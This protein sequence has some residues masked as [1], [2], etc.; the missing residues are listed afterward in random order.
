VTEPLPARRACCF[1]LGPI[2]FE[3]ARDKQRDVPAC[4]KCGPLASHVVVQDH[5]SLGVL[6]V[7][8]ARSRSSGVRFFDGLPDAP[9]R[10]E[11]WCAMT[12]N[13]GGPVRRPDTPE[14][15]VFDQAARR[16]EAEAERARGALQKALHV[17]GRDKARRLREARE[18]EAAERKRLSAIRGAKRAEGRVEGWKA[19]G[20]TLRRMA[21]TPVVLP[22]TPILPRAHVWD[23]DAAD[24][25]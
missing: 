18:E 2:T 7:A 22:G 13:G 21:D 15:F 14:A 11:A 12:A 23:T 4:A 9:I 25:L 17:V 10:A 8:E 24:D 5:P 20:G 1:C 19:N 16:E 3:A 6:I